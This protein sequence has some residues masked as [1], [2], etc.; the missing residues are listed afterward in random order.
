MRKYGVAVMFPVSGSGN[1]L[2]CLKV[3]KQN[4][5]DFAD[6]QISQFQ[7]VQKNLERL[8]IYGVIF[9]VGHSFGHTP[10]LGMSKLADFVEGLDEMSPKLKYHPKLK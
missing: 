1:P 2:Q 9:L 6:L 8:F 3:F 7:P 10:W 4:P 5:Y